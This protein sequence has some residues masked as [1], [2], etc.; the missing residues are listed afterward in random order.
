MHRLYLAAVTALGALVATAPQAQAQFGF[1]RGCRFGGGYG[2]YQAG[3]PVYAYTPYGYPAYG[4]SGIRFGGFTAGI[5]TVGPGV[6]PAPVYP[7]YPMGYGYVPTAPMPIQAQPVIVEQNPYDNS[8]LNEWQ[9]D[10]AMVGQNQP[11][12]EQAPPAQRQFV[13]PAEQRQI[14]EVRMPIRQ[15][16]AEGR[17]KAI[18]ALA[19][20]D[21]AFRVQRWAQAYSKYKEAAT[22]A[23]DQADSHFRMAI[24]LAAMNQFGPAADEFKR[25][26]RIDSSWPVSAATLDDLYGDANVLAKQSMLQSGIAWAR[27]DVRDADRSFVM[28][29]LL[30][31][32]RDPDRAAQFLQA[33]VRLG[34]SN[35]YAQAFLNPQPVQA[36]NVVQP[37]VP[38]DLNQFGRPQ[39]PRAPQ[40][41]PIPDAPQP[42]LSEPQ[43]PPTVVTPLQPALPPNLGSPAEGP[44]LGPALPPAAPPAAAAPIK[45]PITPRSPARDNSD[46][47]GPAI[48]VL[49]AN[50]VNAEPRARIDGPQLVIPSEAIPHEVAAMAPKP[51]ALREVT[52]IP[53]I[54]RS[55]AT[56]FR[57]NRRYE[58]FP[59]KR[60]AADEPTIIEEF[61]PR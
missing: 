4:F 10:Q 35:A 53:P 58:Y 24:T 48:P 17:R 1:Y 36:R 47:L 46:S 29:V 14:P 25:G 26:L 31:L 39:A 16:N 8:V 43:A 41:R 34:G 52:M 28:G 57:G 61:T 3:P 60:V 7:G 50:P 42:Q 44:E 59:R 54:I 6:Y 37:V 21:E 33:S 11:W 12:L 5:A 55:S 23:G 40:K 32:D 27:Q 19:Q 13:Q 30:F 15:S 18:H 9:P 51:E 22:F 56:I 20:G 38:A 49:P 45:K 2:Y